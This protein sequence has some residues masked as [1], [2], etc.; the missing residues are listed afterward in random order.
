MSWR[1]APRPLG[2]LVT[3]DGSNNNTWECP[4]D[5]DGGDGD[6]MAPGRRAP[7]FG[8]WEGA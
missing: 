3:R 4:H 1:Q 5:A 8:S 7:R 6:D 2:R